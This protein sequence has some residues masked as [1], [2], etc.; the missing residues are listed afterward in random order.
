MN[1]LL[2]LNPSNYNRF[3]AVLIRLLQLMIKLYRKFLTDAGFARAGGLAFSTLLAAVPFA[4]LII[5]LLNAFGAL[6][7]VQKQITDFIVQL[8]IPTRQAEISAML[9]QFL[10]N[11]NALGVVGLVF[12]LVTSIMLLNTVNVNLNAVWGSRAKS[13]FISKLSTYAS[14]IIIGTLLLAASTTLSTKFSSLPIDNIAVF[15]RLMLR[16]SPY[17][18]DLLIIMLIIGLTPSGRVKFS[19]IFIASLVGAVFWELLKWGFVNLSGWAIRAS[20]IYGTIAVIPIFLFWVYIIWLIIIGAMELAWL[21]QHKQRQWTGKCLTAM[22]P[23]E[24]LMFG[25]D[26]YLSIAERFHST[27]P[28]PTISELSHKFCM[29][30]EDTSQVISIFS[31]KNLLVQTAGENPGWIP[32]RSLDTVRV[33]E[34]IEAVF[35]ANSIPD[36]SKSVSAVLIAEFYSEGEKAFMLKSV[37]DLLDR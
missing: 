34:L 36:D 3:T 26:I 13:N 22:L 1:K 16:L 19:S 29:P 24:K 37:S 31:A 30:G 23:A 27:E 11:S 33:A 9:D 15:N 28:A 5:S 25:I 35:G 10:A 18:F 12:F 20:I 8:L 2:E 32:S 4:A 17:I 7:S 21:L 14:V 6:D